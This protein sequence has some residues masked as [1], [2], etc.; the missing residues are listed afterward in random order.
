MGVSLTVGGMA[1]YLHAA[2]IFMTIQM[3]EAA[4]PELRVTW[5]SEA[6][7]SYILESSTNLVDWGNALS[8]TL[9]AGGPQFSISLGTLTNSVPW[10]FYRVKEVHSSAPVG[11]VIVEMTNGPGRMGNFIAEDMGPA[12]ASFIEGP[13]HEV[14]LSTFAMDQTLV[15]GQQWSN[16]YNWAINNGY[17]FTNHGRAA[18]DNHPIHT[19]SWYDAVKW[20]NARSEFE[21]IEPAYYIA[22]DHI[23]E[24]VYRTGEV[25][26]VNAWVKWDSGYRLPTESEWEIA[27]RGTDGSHTNRFWWGD[28]ISHS[29]ANYFAGPVGGVEFNLSAG[30]GF[31]PDFLYEEPETELELPGTNPVHWFE[32]NPLGLHDMHGNLIQ[33]CWDWFAPSEYADRE[34][35]GYPVEDP[36]G[37]DEGWLFFRVLRGSS[38]RSV[39]QNTRISNRSFQTPLAANIIIGFRNV[40][41]ITD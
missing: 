39:V 26:I 32:P 30:Q 17:E 9:I 6:G 40:L 3:D 15:T 24:N 8:G 25:S 21:G 13:V 28:T 16:I 36:R 7:K 23:P 22:E 12:G 41:P 34:A 14:E 29:N 33:W 35:L 19:V 31:H 5:K 38:Y 2:D 4:E 1:L 18:G 10:E 37:P 20:S 11:M 27:A